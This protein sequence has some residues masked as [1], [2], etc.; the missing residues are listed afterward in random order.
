M[1]PFSVVVAHLVSSGVVH[2]DFQCRSY[3]FTKQ[4]EARSEALSLRG[5]SLQRHSSGKTLLLVACAGLPQI[6]IMSH[7]L[8]LPNVVQLCNCMNLSCASFLFL[9]R[10]PDW[11]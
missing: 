4:L 6:H 8:K 7:T 1:K 11:I 9:C 5:F 2:V 3:S 10:Y